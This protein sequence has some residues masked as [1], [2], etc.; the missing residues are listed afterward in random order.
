MFA[1][2]GSRPRVRP[3]ASAAGPAGAV[4]PRAPGRRRRGAGP[5]WWPGRH[6]RP[7]VRRRP[8]RPRPTRERPLLGPVAPRLGARVR[9]HRRRVAPDPAV[10]AVAR[11]RRA[12]RRRAGGHRW[13]G[14]RSRRPRLGTARR[15]HGPAAGVRARHPGGHGGDAARRA[16]DRG[17]A[18]AP[19]GER[20]LLVSGGGVVARRHA[21]RHRGG[22]GA[23][24]GGADRPAERLPAVRLG[25]RPG[26]RHRLDRRAHDPDLRR[27]RPALVLRRLRARG[28][29]RDAARV[30]LAPAGGDGPLGSPRAVLARDPPSRGRERAVRE[31]R[32]VRPHPRR[33]RAEAPRLRSAPLAVRPAAAAVLP[34]RL[35]VQRRVRRLLRPRARVSGRPRL[36]L[37]VRLRLLHPLQPGQRRR[38]RPRRAALA[39]NPPP[40][41]PAAGALGPRGALPGRGAGGPPLRVR[42]PD[43]RARRRVRARRT[44]VGRRRRDR[45]GAGVPERVAGAQRGG[46][47]R[48]RGALRP[49]G[50]VDGLLGG[51]VAARFGY[52]PAFALA[53]ALVALSA[54][55]LVSTRFP[56]AAG[57]SADPPPAP[58]GDDPP[59]REG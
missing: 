36:L 27:P 20:R 35:R 1:R 7:S 6:R 29:G 54:G 59:R 33:R 13:T 22:P 9:G 44:H 49:G 31:A 14:R 46:T 19:R 30:L 38:L 28:A 26:R 24:V 18:A 10:R 15:P 2:R 42:S 43:R 25:R 34:D 21:V 51:H 17:P 55:L 45:R 53:G 39:A 47:R 56:F 37:A 23:G 3:R 5:L 4:G 8:P 48:P 52:W 12:R 16:A 57:A 32:P 50:G 41:A 11:G 40:D 58:S